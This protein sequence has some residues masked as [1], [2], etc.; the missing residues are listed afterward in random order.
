VKSHANIVKIPI[1]SK[2]KREK[3]HFGTLKDVAE[4]EGKAK[5][6]RIER[7]MTS[8]FSL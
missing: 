5:E 4:H 6:A 1:A 8:L 2:E 7:N 3:L